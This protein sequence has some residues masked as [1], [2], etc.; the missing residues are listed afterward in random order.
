MAKL[1]NDV[2]I[3]MDPDALRAI[4]QFTEAVGRLIT[5]KEYPNLAGLRCNEC[6]VMLVRPESSEP[7]AKTFWA[8]GDLCPFTK[9]CHGTM[10]DVDTYGT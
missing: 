2:V 3:T 8:A 1:T 9:E 5:D 10:Q 7:T 4:E 6:G